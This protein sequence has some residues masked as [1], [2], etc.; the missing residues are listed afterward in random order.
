VTQSVME[1]E[2][3]G[4]NALHYAGS[5]TGMFLNELTFV[6]GRESC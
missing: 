5:S 6:F 3:V 4:P 1:Q 2:G